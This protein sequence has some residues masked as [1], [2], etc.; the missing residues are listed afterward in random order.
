MSTLTRRRIRCKID[1][2]QKT[3]FK[4]VD[5]KTSSTPEFWRGNDLQ[6][7][8]GIAWNGSLITDIS[9]IAS[10]TL[11]VKASAAATEILMTKT[12]AAV[13]LVNTV[14]EANWADDSNQHALV[15]FT[16]T[17]ANIVAGTYH[18]GVSVVTSDSPGRDITLGA[19]T[20]VV[21]E[22]GAGASGTPQV[23]DGLAYTQAEADARFVQAHQDQA[24]MQFS[25]GKWYIYNG[26]TSLWYPLVC[27][28]KDSVPM[29][30]LGEGVAL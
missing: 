19:T 28:I 30:T 5:V 7:E 14:T 2:A 8:I 26:D 4:F 6:F 17:E 24:W 9:N 3:T 27:T 29:L 23:T 25:G 11:Q 1:A 15:A 12:L 21:T 20:L 10:L 18:M 13:D 22:D 16:G